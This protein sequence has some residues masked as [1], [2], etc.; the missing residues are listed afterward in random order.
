MRTVS[1]I[2]GSEVGDER[3][4]A[5]GWRCVVFPEG[6]IYGNELRGWATTSNSF[7]SLFG[8]EAV[9][10]VTNPARKPELS[11]RLVGLYDIVVREANGTNNEWTGKAVK[12]KTPQSCF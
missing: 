5:M 2:D 12:H 10:R 4:I 9:G 11:R 7:D 3:S 8:N 6:R 1:F